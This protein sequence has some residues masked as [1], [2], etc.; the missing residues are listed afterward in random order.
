MISYPAR[1]KEDYHKVLESKR[2]IEFINEK[3]EWK[4]DCEALRK[5][6]N[7]KTRIFILNNPNNPTGK[8]FTESELSEIANVLKDFPRIIVVSD[9]VYEKVYFDDNLQVT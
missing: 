7:K 2:K 6:F 4:L 1:S 8:I 3:D 5:A 9:E